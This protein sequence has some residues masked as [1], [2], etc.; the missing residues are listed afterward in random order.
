MTSANCL[1]VRL[2][3]RRRVAPTAPEHVHETLLGANRAVGRAYCSRMATAA[4][5]LRV[6]ATEA[7]RN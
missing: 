4:P 5:G 1:Q 7:A 3:L 2:D 6:V